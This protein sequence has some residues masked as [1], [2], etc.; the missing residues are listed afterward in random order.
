MLES[1][2][3]LTS[4]RCFCRDSCHMSMMKFALLVKGFPWACA[5]QGLADLGEA[6]FDKIFSSSSRAASAFE[7]I[8]DARTR[9]RC[10]S[11]CS[12]IEAGI[13]SFVAKA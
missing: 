7:T 6:S 9:P 1:I 3:S 4:G 11:I 8:A 12:S 5:A 10:F 2:K 13:S